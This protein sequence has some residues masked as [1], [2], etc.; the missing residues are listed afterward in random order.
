MVVGL[1]GLHHGL[2]K[3]KERIHCPGHMQISNRRFHCW[4][5]GGHG[6][7]TMTSALRESC[8][9]YFYDLAIRLG[10]ERITETAKILGLGVRP[11]LPLPAVRE[12][13]AP[14]KDWKKRVHGEEW[15]PGDTANSGI[16]QGFVL[17]SPIQLAMMT[18]R[19]ATGKNV[20]PRMINMLGGKFSDDLGGEDLPFD[21]EHLD[22][23]RRGMWE[24]SNHGRG[25]ARGSALR[26]KFKMAG[27]TGTS[28]VRYITAQERAQGV[29][30]N[31]DL[32]WHRR[33][34]ALFVGFAPFE[35]P[36]YAVS[37]IVEHGGGGSRAAA[38]IARDVM[39]RV[40]ALEEAGYGQLPNGQ[41]SRT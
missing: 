19:L 17:A 36:R 3:E 24:V 7:M 31:E 10:I 37:V 21:K 34:H 28:Q 32:P 39:Q 40:L 41:R 9:V 11:D 1:A 15:F 13:L 27:K 35:N 33:D 8:D 2:I 18:S 5:A 12:G 20:S 16:G 4:R 14:T 23:I 6:R 22:I 30:K 26:G 38:P 29:T 25:T